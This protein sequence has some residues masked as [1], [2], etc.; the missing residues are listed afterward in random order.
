MAQLNDLLVLGKSNLLGDTSI[1][2]AFNINGDVLIDGTLTVNEAALFKSSIEASGSATIGGSGTIK[3]R[4]YAND[5]INLPGDK[6]IIQSQRTGSNY[7]ALIEW[8]WADKGSYSY[9]PQIGHHSNADDGNGALILM[10]APS[11]TSPWSQGNNTLYLSNSRLRWNNLIQMD[12]SRNFIPTENDKGSIGTSSYYWNNGYLTN[13]TIKTALTV[14]GSASIAGTLVLSKTTDASG[15]AN[16]SPALIVGGTATTAHIEIDNNEILAKK[17]GTEVTTLNLNTDG[18]AVSIGSGG[19][20]ITG[21]LTA[22]STTT[23][24]GATTI[25]NNVT[26]SNGNLTIYRESSKANNTPAKIIFSNKQT[27]TPITT[28]SAFIAVYDDADANAYGQNMVIQA[29]SNIVIG[30]GESASGFYAANLTTSQSENVYL[31]ADSNI[32]FYTKC[33]TVANAVGIA[34]DTSRQFY[35]VLSAAGNAGSLGTSSYRWSNAYIVTLNTSGAATIGTDLTVSGNTVLKGT[36]EVTGISTF[37]ERIV[38]KTGD[39]KGAKLGAAY[40]TSASDTNGEVVLQ[41]GHLR[42]GENA[43]DYNQWAGLKYTHSNKTIYLGLADNSIFTAN[44]AQSGGIIRTPGISTVYANQYKASGSDGF[45]LIYGNYGVIHR[46][47][48]SDYYILLTDSGSADNGSWNGLRPFRINLSTGNVYMGTPV[49]MASSASVGTTLSVGST[50]T[51]SGTTLLKNTLTVENNIYIKQT[52][53]T[54]TGLGLYG[55][56]APTVYG[57]YFAQTTNFGKHGDVQ[58]D[59]ATYFGMNAVGTRGWIFRPG[60]TNVASI[61][62]NGV[63][64]FS[65]IGDGTA[66]MAFPKGGTLT[67]G[68]SGQKGYLTIVFPAGF[69]STMLKFKVSVYNYSTGTSV[70]YIIGGYCYSSEN[71]WYNPTAYCIG[72]RGSG[73]AN[74]TV[75]Y[76]MSGSNPA[77]QIGAANTSW[78]YPNIAIS[79]VYLGHGRNYSDWSKSWTVSITTTA[80]TSITQTVSNTYMGNFSGTDNKIAK[81]TSS[82]KTITNSNITDDG[83]TVTIGTKLVVQGNGSSYNEGIRILPASNGWSNIFFSANSEVQGTHDGGWLIGRRGAAGDV[84]AVGDFTI[85]EQNSTGVNFTIHKDGNGATLIGS[86]RT[87]KPIIYSTEASG[88]RILYGGT[89]NSGMKYDYNGNE[90][91]MISAGTYA[92]ASIQFLTGGQVSLTDSNGQW[93][94]T[95]PAMSL[96]K[97][98]VAVNYNLTSD[99]THNFYVK[100]TSK[101]DGVVFGYNYTNSNNAAAFVWDKNGS[102]YTGVG[103][104]NTADTIYFGACGADGS[105]VTSY[106]QKWVFNGTVS[107]DS[108]NGTASSANVLKINNTA[109]LSDC[110]QYIQTSSQ[111]SGKDLPSS[112]WYH[113]LKMN[114]GNGDTYYKR[115][116]AFNFWGPNEVYT[117]TA[118]GNG[119][120]G[121][122][123]KFWLQGDSVTGAVWNDYAECRESDC[124]DFGYVLTETGKDNLVKTSV[125]L[126]HF[127]GI[128]SDTWGFSQGETDK[129][130]TPIAVAGRVLAYTYQDRNNYKPGDCVCAAPGGTVDIMTREEIIQYPDRIVGTVSCVPEYEEWGGGELSDR[131]PVKVNKRIWIKVK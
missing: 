12:S 92:S 121:T 114:H 86:L 104:C 71:K 62:A 128:S 115:L 113:V 50:L 17:N 112:T 119:T 37:K 38:L 43:W 68:S 130:K 24:K 102:N 80:I 6:R 45:K 127:A 109:G 61:S 99:P 81:F 49:S 28:N 123:K 76:G 69:S 100:G 36:L 29:A 22:N 88:T 78:E 79:D 13:L 27:D 65:A 74:L 96:R 33:D 40:I 70:D 51:V 39:K 84:G 101:F 53:G 89:R 20:S 3:G 91:L 42:F 18:G 8:N 85:E 126:Q 111:T 107:A 108:F 90:C 30:A 10:Y 73:L 67:I 2:G 44:A 110:L 1:F 35:P 122:W 64:S 46:N 55:T 116:L 7:T 131:P 57:I 87:N 14:S 41:G 83:S 75:N 31:T 54:G 63:A 9:Y 94:T 19:L 82:G 93:S 48:N 32:Y 125:R 21:A 58:S 103:S 47:D 60:S 124:E 4:L 118:E 52:A 15:T 120:V 72:P 77:I 23:I 5:G 25:Q 59:W 98:G 95:A 26:V 117:A 105:W 66:Y 16:N 11:N 97:S 106:K 34:L 129:A 56:S